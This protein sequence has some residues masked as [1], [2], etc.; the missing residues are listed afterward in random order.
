MERLISALCSTHSLYNNDGMSSY[1]SSSDDFKF[2]RYLPILPLLF[3]SVSITITLW[4]SRRF[5]FIYSR[6]EHLAHLLFWLCFFHIPL[7]SLVVLKREKTFHRS[8]AAVLR[9]TS[10]SA[11]GKSWLKSQVDCQ[12]RK[13]FFIASNWFHFERIKTL[14]D[15]IAEYKSKTSKTF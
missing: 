2:H 14:F 3:L 6:D 13:L 10:S 15:W 8:F 4:K 9:L 7:C 11:R 1:L 5:K 12:I